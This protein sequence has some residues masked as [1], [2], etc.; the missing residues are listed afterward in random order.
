MTSTN[1]GSAHCRSSTTRT[2]GRAAGE[3]LEHLAHRPACLLGRDGGAPGREQVRDARGG[4]LGVSRRALEQARLAERL[5]EWPP[6]QAVAVGQASAGRDRRGAIDRLQDL[7][8][9]ARLAD[10]S[11]AHDGEQLA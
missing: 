6:G 1:V 8:H 4:I 5:G 3:R 9:Q 7:G 11:R 2:N 10:T